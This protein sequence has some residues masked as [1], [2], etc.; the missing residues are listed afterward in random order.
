LYSAI[1]LQ[2]DSCNIS[3]HIISMSIHY[4]VKLLMRPRSAFSNS[5]VVFVAVSKFGKTNAIFGN[6][7]A[8]INDTHTAVMCCWLSSYALSCVRSL[9]SSLSASKTVL[10]YTQHTRSSAFWN[11]RH[12]LSFH[13]P[14]AL[15][16]HIWTQMT[17]KFGE[18]CRRNF[19][20]LMNWMSGVLFGA[21]QMSGANI[22]VCLSVCLFVQRTFEHLIWFNST[23]THTC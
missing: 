19:M 23:H 20:T 9:A 21:K 6:A 16:V 13:P 10:L 2:P 14:V 3:H 1:N 18:K 7:G 15:T 11:A 4:L 12:P 5:L 22:S 17:T 8:K